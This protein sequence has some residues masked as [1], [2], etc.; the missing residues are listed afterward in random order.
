MTL[1]DFILQT[2]GQC[3]LFIPSTKE[4]RCIWSSCSNRSKFVN[5]VEHAY[6]CPLGKFLRDKDQ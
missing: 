2:Y 4:F 3:Y 6:D 1:E 5:T